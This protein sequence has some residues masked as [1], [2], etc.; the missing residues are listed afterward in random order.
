MPVALKKVF[1]HPRPEAVIGRLGKLRQF[2]ANGLPTA[3]FR[4]TVPAA[5]L[6][7][8]YPYVLFTEPLFYMR[9]SSLLGGDLRRAGS[10]RFTPHAN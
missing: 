4:W 7:R 8:S 3:L 2:N 9:L 6:G 5:Y 10:N 1:T